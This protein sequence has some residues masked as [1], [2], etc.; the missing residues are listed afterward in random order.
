VGGAIGGLIVIFLT[1]LGIVLIRRKHG[2]KV[3]AISPTNGEN[4]GRNDF[5]DDA[6]LNAHELG[7]LEKPADLYTGEHDNTKPFELS[8]D[9]GTPRTIR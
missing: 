8:G 4:Q 6:P 5:A 1:I 9:V 2:A 3:Q 7:D